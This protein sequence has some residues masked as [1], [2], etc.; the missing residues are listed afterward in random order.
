MNKLRVGVLRGGVSPEYHVS[1]KTGQAVL[2]HLPTDKYDPVDVLITKDGQWHVNGL[3]A[4]LERVS[5][6]TDIIFNA[7]HGE[8]GEDGKVQRELEKW[9]I[10][11][12]GSGIIGSALGMHKAFAREHFSKAGLRV[13]LGRWIRGD[14][15][16]EKKM[17]EGSAGI[18]ALSFEIFRQIT[19]PWIVKPISG[20]SSVGVIIV[21]SFPELKEVFES[22]AESG[23][24]LLVEELIRGK[25]A[26]CG[27]IE[28]FRGE[29][30]YA[31]LPTEIR[32]HEE[33]DFF[34]YEA[35]YEGKSHE[36][37]PGSFSREESEM[38]QNAARLAHKALG[39]RHYSRADFMVTP[40]GIYILETNTLPGLTEES[41]VP[42][43]LHAV[44]SSLPE[45]L[46]HV[47]GLAA[48][49]RSR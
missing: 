21:R 37:T 8:Y 38:I 29:D 9:N 40:R 41:L 35:K 12:T 17:K 39:L 49:V 6:K 18:S 28:N 45:F 19:P 14:D 1:L 15:F 10:P 42:Q 20:G 30:L 5:R 2:R 16:L 25:E 48:S 23:E 34:D 4:N 27:V 24:D 13:P 44:G 46:D 32:P 11:Y 3:P 47:I 33:K 26:T 22:A 31:L 7:L 43:Q 36:I